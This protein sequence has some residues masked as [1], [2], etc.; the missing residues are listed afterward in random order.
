VALP[1]A[2]DDRV[3]LVLAGGGARGAYE[4]GAL[5]VLL[6]FLEERGERPSIIVGTSV[7][8]LTAAFVAATADKPAAA[9]IAEG[10]RRWL[11]IGKDDVIGPVLL[12]QA[13]MTAAR[14]VGSL[15]PLGGTTVSS[16]LDPAPLA[17]NLD[18]WIDW[19]SVRTNIDAGVV[20]TLAVVATAAA[21]GR[22][23]AFLD[24]HMWPRIP[25][26]HFVDYVAAEVGNSHVRA[27]AAI[28]I[29]FPAVRVDTPPEAAGWYLDGGIRFNTPIKPALDLGADRLVVVGTGSIDRAE[30]VVG[31][32]V[33]APPSLAD[34]ALHVL[35]G[36]LVDPLVEDLRT[37]GQINRFYL[38]EGGGVDPDAAPARLRA[39]EGKDPYRL[40][41][42]IFAGPRER[43]AIGQLAAEMFQA[44]YGG[45][46]ALRS[47]D[48]GI[49]NAVLDADSPQHGELLSYL[50]FD[51]EFIE[52]L[53]RL[54]REDCE[55]WL[56]QA[57]D[58]GPVWRVGPPDGE[59]A[60]APAEKADPAPPGDGA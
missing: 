51:A 41:P 23:V 34:A 40:V 35:H 14:V 45:P 32:D 43:G 8:A 47:L 7:G 53:I 11:E 54:G 13:P 25:K 27:S 12:K 17:K 55:A 29:V 33:D 26:S 36:T 44:R 49:L 30:H 42:Y 57:G 2:G 52:E 48:F 24:T 6:P 50:F 3:A 15:L 31:A 38:D 28:P 4:A 19:N 22:T 1:E 10:T 39:A 21:T 5:S 59:P 58:G 56:R 18:T 9:A 60:D 37:L 46:K 16:L 20:Q